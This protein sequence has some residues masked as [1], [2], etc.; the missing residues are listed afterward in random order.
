MAAH[1]NI[2]K[3]TLSVASRDYFSSPPDG[4][5]VVLHCEQGTYDGSNRARTGIWESAQNPHTAS[6]SYVTVRKSDTIDEYRCFADV[7]ERVAAMFHSDI[8]RAGDV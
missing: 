6:D 1:I 4:K 8:D 7:K 3:W 2:S 5:R